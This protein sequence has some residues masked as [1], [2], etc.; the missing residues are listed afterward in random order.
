MERARS[1]LSRPARILLL[2]LIA[3]SLPIGTAARA[4]TPADTARGLLR[5]YHEDPARIDRARQLLEAHV[6][7]AGPDAATLVAL[8]RAWFLTAEHRAT[9]EAARLAAYE[10]GRDIAHQAITLAPDD[11]GPHLWYAINL[12]SWASAKGLLR[13]LLALRTI[14]AE[15]ETVLRLDPRSLEAHVMA[16]S[17]HRELPAVLGGDRARAERHYRA[18]LAL[19]PEH[20]SV[21]V[22]LAVLHIATGRHADARRELEAVLGATAPSDRPRW[23]TRDLPRAQAL[24]DSLNDRR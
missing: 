15:V 13:S 24:L 5:G 22:E 21:R 23:A 20:T 6:S 7:R 4:G 16:G 1:A 3:A 14:R 8:A 19:D 18:A 11:P 10:R 17:I 9:N 2:G 12:G